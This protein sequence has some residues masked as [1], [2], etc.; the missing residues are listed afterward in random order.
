MAKGNLSTKCKKI[1]LLTYGKGYGGKCWGDKPGCRG[2]GP[3]KSRDKDKRR[4]SWDK[5]NIIYFCP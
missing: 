1:N 3:R 2:D 4:S 5:M